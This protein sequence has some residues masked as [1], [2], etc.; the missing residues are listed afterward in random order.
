MSNGL[1]SNTVG[2]H[3]VNGNLRIA[4]GRGLGMKLSRNRCAEEKN[5]SH[6]KTGI[7]KFAHAGARVT[8]QSW[9]NWQRLITPHHSR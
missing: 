1:M 4:G 3:A 7:A 2:Y 8:P 5:K 9:R 6:Y